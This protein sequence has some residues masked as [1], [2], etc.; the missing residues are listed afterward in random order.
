MDF[1]QLKKLVVDRLIAFPSAPSSFSSFMLNR[2]SDWRSISSDQWL[3]LF[4]IVKAEAMH[5]LYDFTYFANSVLGINVYSE[6]LMKC[7]LNKTEF[8]LLCGMIDPSGHNH[9]N[10]IHFFSKEGVE[11]LVQIRGE[12]KRQ[13]LD[14]VEVEYEKFAPQEDNSYVMKRVTDGYPEQFSIWQEEMRRNIKE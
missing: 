5:G 6:F 7:Q 8:E 3:E 4:E 14:L 12:L 9:L 13:S 1:E 11:K 2:S 10:A